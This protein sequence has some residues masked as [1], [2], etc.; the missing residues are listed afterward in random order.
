MDLDLI[1]TA[2]MQGFT[3]RIC[4]GALYYGVDVLLEIPA[5]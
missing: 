1:N 3:K 4:K 5:W 2:K